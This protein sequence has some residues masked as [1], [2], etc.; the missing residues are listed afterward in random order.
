MKLKTSELVEMLVAETTASH[1]LCHQIAEMAMRC[2]PEP[3]KAEMPDQFDPE[4][5]RYPIGLRA[6]NYKK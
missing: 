2:K 1:R 4:V 5:D 6:T 3:Q